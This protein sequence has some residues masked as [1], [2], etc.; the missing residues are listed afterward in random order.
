[1]PI[2]GGKSDSGLGAVKS[3]LPFQHHT[4][5]FVDDVL[6]FPLG[7]H[8]AIEQE[9]SAGGKLFD[10]AKIVGNEKDR[11]LTVF[12]FLHL[13]DAAVGKDGVAHRQGF[14]HNQDFRIHVDGGGERQAHVHAAG[15]LFH[16]AI[17][18]I[19]N[20]RKGFDRGQVAFHFRAADPHDLAIDE[21]VL[22]AGKLRIEA[23][24]QFQ[25]GRNA[26]AS[27]HT[28]AGGLQ[29]AARNLQQ[30]TLAAAVGADQADNLP[31]LHVE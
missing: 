22:H 31:A 18:E 10:Q 7:F 30:G 15:V 27:D 29:N 20:L 24:A 5:V 9:H 11:D 16:R 14:V 8:L 6:G 26:P 3:F 25:Q 12:Q 2:A 19:S 23:R 4:N 13:A 1:M 28:T 21:D 17:N